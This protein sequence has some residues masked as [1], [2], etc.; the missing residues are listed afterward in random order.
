MNR[1]GRPLGDG[2]PEAVVRPLV[3]DL[4]AVEERRALEAVVLAGVVL[5]VHDT[6]GRPDAY[7]RWV[8][9]PWSGRLVHVPPPPAARERARR[10]AIAGLARGAWAALTLVRQRLG[11][12]YR[13]VDD[14][15]VSAEDIMRMPVCVHDLG[16][17]RTAVLARAMYEIDPYLEIECVDVLVGVDQLDVLLFGGNAASRWESAMRCARAR[18][19][20]IGEVADCVDATALRHL[21]TRPHGAAST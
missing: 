2:R 16:A 1:S 9:F 14:G 20:T 15:V 19:V 10:I 12:A 7:G 6:V 3:F 18:G 17:P 5:T 8:L 13:L 4:G 21:V 11:R